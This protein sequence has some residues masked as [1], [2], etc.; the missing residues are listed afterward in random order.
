MVRR[1]LSR[2]PDLDGFYGEPVELDYRTAAQYVSA[3]EGTADDF[4]TGVVYVWNAQKGWWDEKD[5]AP[6]TQED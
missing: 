1:A 6:E 2:K 3:Y 4:E 5:A